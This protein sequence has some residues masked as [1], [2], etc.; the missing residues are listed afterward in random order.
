[1]LTMQVVMEA[2]ARVIAMPLAVAARLLVLGQVP[3]AGLLAPE[4]LQPR[5]FLEVLER[6]GVHLHYRRGTQ[7]DRFL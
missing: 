2:D 7:T 6:W 1:M 5:P 3:R 4:T